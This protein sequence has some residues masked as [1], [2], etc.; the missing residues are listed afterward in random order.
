MG[1]TDLGFM[2]R[3]AGDEFTELQ[4]HLGHGVR[5][6]TMNVRVQRHLKLQ[7][8]FQ[9]H[10]GLAQVQLDEARARGQKGVNRVQRGEQIRGAVGS[11]AHGAMGGR[12]QPFAEPQAEFR[13]ARKHQSVAQYP[14]L[15]RS[16]EHAVLAQK[17]RNAELSALQQRGQL[18]RREAQLPR[19]QPRVTGRNV[20]LLRQC[21]DF[22]MRCPH[23]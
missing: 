15:L 9:M 3:T 8:A 4:Q 13:A 16:G 17:L 7:L 14:H 5:Q 20:G 23:A 19:N 1:K 12:R 2:Q 10:L 11:K 22:K 6:T 18:A 21:S